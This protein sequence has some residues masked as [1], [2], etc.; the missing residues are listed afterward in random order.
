MYA[1]TKETN[2][3]N[4]CSGC[5]QWFLNE[6]KKTMDFLVKSNALRSKSGKKWNDIETEDNNIDAL[7][8]KLKLM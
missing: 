4:T 3:F 8:N 1:A 6:K 2:E 5:G 7:Q